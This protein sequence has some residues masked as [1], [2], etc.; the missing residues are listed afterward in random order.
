MGSLAWRRR[1]SSS[2]ATS[3]TCFRTLA[4]RS[5]YVVGIVV[6]SW[7][8]E[9]PFPGRERE[10]PSNIH[11]R[12]RK[13]SASEPAARELLVLGE[14]VDLGGHEVHQRH[15]Q[16]DHDAGPWLDEA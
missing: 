11:A 2:S 7:M 15:G 6:F 12:T 8:L 9:A 1:L 14:V 4:I 3:L 16:E 13:T 10:W 5:V